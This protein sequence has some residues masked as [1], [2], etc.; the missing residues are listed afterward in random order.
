VAVPSPSERTEVVFT[1]G[2]GSDVQ[3]ESE[4]P[5]PGARSEGVRILRAQA[6]SG[7]LRLVLEGR[8]GRTY[9]LRA[10]SPHGLGAAA[11]VTVRPLGG[12]LHEVQVRFDGPG[13]AYVRRDIALPLGR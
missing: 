12:L 13:D 4:E 9:T 1:Y 5:V 2:E 6:E 10:R 3:A 8:A 7:A 11:G